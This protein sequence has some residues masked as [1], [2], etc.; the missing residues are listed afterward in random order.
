MSLLAVLLFMTQDLVA[1]EQSV[2]DAEYEAVLEDDR[3]RLLRRDEASRFW[4]GWIHE[5][6]K[7]R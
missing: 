3:I 5:T 2:R 1:L 4:R 7:Q 6:R